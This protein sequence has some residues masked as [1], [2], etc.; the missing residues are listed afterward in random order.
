[1]KKLR[2][3]GLQFAAPTKKSTA[4]S[5]ALSSK[6]NW[7]ARDDIKLQDLYDEHRAMTGTFLVKPTLK[8]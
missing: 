4:R 5:A 8:Y 7:N 2:E 3:L 1:M 6:S